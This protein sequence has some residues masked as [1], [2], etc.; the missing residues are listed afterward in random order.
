[1]A[2]PLQGSLAGH[3]YA[4]VTTAGKTWQADR[5]FLVR[6]IRFSAAAGSA[7]TTQTCSI[8][9]ENQQLFGASVPVRMLDAAA[10]DHN[11]LPGVDNVIV[12]KPARP[13]LWSPGFPM[14]FVPSGTLQ[15]LIIAEEI[16]SK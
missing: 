6:E 2:L 10:G 11:V 3:V 8:T 7:I 16:P 1:M 4:S 14:T 5:T 15:I 12:F 13:F 9:V